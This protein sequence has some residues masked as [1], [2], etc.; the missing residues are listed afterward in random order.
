[1][2]PISPGAILALFLGAFPLAAAEMIPAALPQADNDSLAKE[3]VAAYR[4]G[5]RNGALEM[6]RPLAEGGNADALF[7]MGFLLESA[8]EPARLSR[9][10]AM[11]YY[12]RRAEAAGH[13]E[14]P[15]RRK[16][17]LL[18][19]GT[20]DEQKAVTALLESAADRG[21][22]RSARI[23]G[24]AWLRG[25]VDGTPD[26][27]KA[28]QRWTAA[29][30]AGDTASLILLARLHEG[31]FGFPE[32][33]DPGAAMEFYHRAA[34]LG[35]ADACIPLGMLLLAA[36]KDEGRDWLGKA[37]DQGLHRAR[38]VMGDHELRVRGDRK[39]ALE[40]YSKG[41]EAGNRQCMHRLAKLLLEDAN[42][43]GER[44]RGQE[45]LRKAAEA[46]DPAAAADLGL[47]LLGGEAP[48][49]A[50]ARTWLISAAMEKVPEAQYELGILYLEGK[51]CS[52]D[53]VAAVAWLTEAMKGG[54]P[55]VQFKLATLHEEGIGTSVN[56]ANAGVL[57]T[58]ACN[59]GHGPAATRIARMAAEGL[60]T[61]PSIPKAWAYAAL[62]VER[63]DPPAKALHADLDSKLAPPD[64]PLA[65]EALAGLRSQVKAGKQSSGATTGS[66]KP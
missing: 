64:K 18:A 15:G 33:R 22:A 32:K 4:E 45:L 17:V 34:K 44:T 16:L 23:L 55:E 46:G 49:Y 53:P 62:A 19:S 31:E 39:A 40:Q 3:A 28:L 27:T 35:E 66:G 41:M 48:D 65:E 7:L 25:L 5:R 29:A 38:L 50:S 42:S 58:L 14:A 52:R 8:P 61:E 51:G 26:W 12:Y 56:Y 1:M 24:E 60:G 43:P 9:G 30:D 36:G 21:D 37:L 47:R 57:Y 54:D 59:K 2:R 11:S 20:K 13:P 63:G 10:Q 6:A